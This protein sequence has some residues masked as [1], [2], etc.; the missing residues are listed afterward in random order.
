MKKNAKFEA[1]I[2]TK[3]ISELSKEFEAE[4]TAKIAEAL[5]KIAAESKN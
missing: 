4:F 1:E 2:R 3:I 5:E